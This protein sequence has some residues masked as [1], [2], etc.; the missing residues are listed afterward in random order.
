MHELVGSLCW[1]VGSIL[2]EEMDLID[3]QLCFVLFFFLFFNL[4]C[5]DLELWNLKF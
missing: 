4:I 2:I 3:A 1:I 5:L